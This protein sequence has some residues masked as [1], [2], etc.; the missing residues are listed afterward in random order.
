MSFQPFPFVVEL[1]RAHDRRCG[2]RR[3]AVRAR[4]VVDSAS[5]RVTAN[6]GPARG[7]SR[8]RSSPCAARSGRTR[9]LQRAGWDPVVG[10]PDEPGPE[11][12]TRP[13]SRYSIRFGGPDPPGVAEAPA[14]RSV[15]GVRPILGL[16]RRL[17][18]GLQR[19]VSRARPELD[20]AGPTP[21][22]PDEVEAHRMV[23]RPRASAPAERHVARDDRR[24]LCRAGRG[25][26]EDETR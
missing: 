1:D 12:R 16:R 19:P 13:R 3:V 5:R 17:P 25:Q 23:H 24:H 15:G 11:A 10:A 6:D 4:G 2:G 7:S 21:V 8:P 18:R 20:R 22:Q 14:A 26:R 9:L